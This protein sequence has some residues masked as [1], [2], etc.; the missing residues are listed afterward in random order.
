MM[1][2]PIHP[3]N[4]SLPPLAGRPSSPKI[5][6]PAFGSPLGVAV[7]SKRYDRRWTMHPSVAFA[8]ASG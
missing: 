6:D 8:A 2:I 5:A 3:L 7:G 4:A 1:G